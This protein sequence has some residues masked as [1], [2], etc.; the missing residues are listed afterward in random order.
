[1]PKRPNTQ[2]FSNDEWEEPRERICDMYLYQKLLLK[3]ADGVI[4]IM[5][6]EGFPATFR[7]WNLRKYNKCEEATQTCQTFESEERT[8]PTEIDNTTNDVDLDFPSWLNE[9]F[10]IADL[11]TAMTFSR[12]I[13]LPPLPSTQLVVA[14]TS[15]SD[16]LADLLLVLQSLS[17]PDVFVG[18]DWG[19]FCKLH[20]EVKFDVR[21]DGR[22][23]ASIVNGYTGLQNIPPAG[24]LRFLCR[25]PSMQD[26][27]F[28]CLKNAQSRPYLLD[29]GW[30]NANEVVCHFRGERHTPLETAAVKQS[31]KVLRLLIDKGVDI[32]KNFPRDHHKNAL[33]MLIENV[34]NRRGTLE[35]NL[36]SLVDAFL[37]AEAT[38]S[39]DIIFLALYRLGDTRASVR[40]MEGLLEAICNILNEQDAMS[41][42]NLIE[43][44][45]R[46]L[47][48]PG[49][50][51]RFSQHIEDALYTAVARGHHSV[52]E[53]L[54]IYTPFPCE[55]YKKIFKAENTAI[56]QPPGLG[57]FDMSVA[58]GAALAHK[59]DDLAWSLVGVTLTTYFNRTALDF[60]KVILESG[61]D[62]QIYRENFHQWTIL[63]AALVCSENSVFDEIWAAQKRGK[64]LFLAMVDARSQERGHYLHGA[65]EIAVV[66]QDISLLDELISHGALVDDDWLLR[67]AVQEKC[68]SMIIPFLHRYKKAFPDGRTEYARDVVLSTLSKRSTTPKLLDIAF[69]LNLVGPNIDQTHDCFVAKRFIDAGCNVNSTMPE[70]TFATY[71][72]I[73]TT[74]LLTASETEIVEM[75]Q[76]LIDHGA[77]AV[78]KNNMA[79]VLLLLSRGADVNAIPAMFGGVTALQFAAIHGDCEMAKLL[80][81]HGAE[82]DIKKSDG[83]HGRM[84]LEGAAENGRLDMIEL[85]WRAF[86]GRFRDDQCRDAIRRA[87]SHGYFGCKEMIEELMRSST[88]NGIALPTLS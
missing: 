35:D 41:V 18:E 86:N 38:V 26:A 10:T 34:D 20:H 54:I 16:D 80:I 33:H 4:D 28:N 76:F 42:I 1:M 13:F 59:F 45:C 23:I 68:H 60:A 88:R 71:N 43:R 36:L 75:V 52:V 70:D 30:V 39:I 56:F 63:E 57:E 64:D 9:E 53:I 58:L 67:I 77:D 73:R 32:H 69:D 14:S 5:A 3:D 21:F 24:V 8:P 29:S 51:Y 22:L 65:M 48:K 66:R 15:T 12:Q 40:L 31:F 81:D 82:N 17:P 37:K 87:E 7:G 83:R 85:L 47:G 27:G 50:L 49:D 19:R 11:D 62:V 79:I 6:N 84:P 78:E 2:I 72:H 55:V 74:P 44:K 25:H 46:E 61:W